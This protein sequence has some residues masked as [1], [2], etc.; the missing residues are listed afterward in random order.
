MRT[1]AQENHKNNDLDKVK[2]AEEVFEKLVAD[3]FVV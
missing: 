1:R 2:D 3:H